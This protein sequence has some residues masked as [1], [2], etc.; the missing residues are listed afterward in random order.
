MVHFGSPLVVFVFSALSTLA[1]LNDGQYQIV[2]EY[3]GRIRVL[4]DNGKGVPTTIE[5]INPN[6][7]RKI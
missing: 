5:S 2:N 7:T 4:T 6:D 3:G 1:K